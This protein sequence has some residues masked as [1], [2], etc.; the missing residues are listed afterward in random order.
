VKKEDDKVRVVIDSSV[1]IS[2][3]S[4][5]DKFH[6]TAIDIMNKIR[7]E[8]AEI[9]ISTLVLPEVCGGIVR[10]IKDK[11][12]AKQVKSQIDRWVV[13][14]FFNVQELS[15]E[16][17]MSAA[18]FAIDFG[19]RGA[20]AIIASLAKELGAYLITFDDNLKKK[21]KGKVKLFEL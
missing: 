19:V 5:G 7:Q 6:S 11:T 14:G 3:F 8:K 1:L 17:M 10:V 9:H 15:E 13:S 20:D 4:E 18:E 21:I 2:L 16:R 12:R